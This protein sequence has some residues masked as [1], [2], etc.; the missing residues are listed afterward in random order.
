MEPGA[1]LKGEELRAIE[2]IGKLSPCVG[3]WLEF[4]LPRYRF[5]LARGSNSWVPLRIKDERGLTDWRTRRWWNLTTSDRPPKILHVT[6]EALDLIERFLAYPP[7]QQS[8]LKYFA[9]SYGDV[10]RF[11][12]TRKDESLPSRRRATG[13]QC[14]HNVPGDMPTG[15]YA[16]GKVRNWPP[17]LLDA[18]DPD[19]RPNNYL[20][21]GCVQWTYDNLVKGHGTDLNPFMVSGEMARCVE[22]WGGLLKR[23]DALPGRI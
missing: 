8:Y 17:E 14:L 10:V 3:V 19:L 11:H 4:F 2:R 9:Y 13:V 7:C 21:L 6:L 22:R 5:Y 18:S 1:P 16:V 12:V 23:S 15:M 20:P